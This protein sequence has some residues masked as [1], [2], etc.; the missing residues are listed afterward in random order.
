MASA[1]DLSPHQPPSAGCA[2]SPPTT[3]AGSALLLPHTENTSPLARC[4]ETWH[5]RLCDVH[6]CFCE[7]P[8]HC[9]GL[10][11]LRQLLATRQWCAAPGE[12]P[13]LQ[14]LE[15][16]LLIHDIFWGVSILPPGV[17]PSDI[18]P[19]EVPNYPST[20]LVAAAITAKLADELAAG[21]IRP[22]VERPSHL[23]AIY[24]K[25]EPGSVRVIS[26]FS[27]PEGR[28]LNDYTDNM[29][30][31]M[32]SHED[33]FAL[34]R[35]GAHMAKLDIRKA[36]RAIGVRPEQWH[37]LAFAWQD[38]TTGVTTY[39]I[40]TRLPFGHAK[41][42][43]AFCRIAA[44]VRAMM[45]A[46]GYQATINYVDDFFVVEGTA[47]ECELASQALSRLLPSLG[48][49]ENLP[50][51]CPPATQQI[52]LGLLYNTAALGP[53]PMTITV[54][55]DKLRRAERIA[56]SLATQSSVS[57][58]T[59]QSAIGFFN[60]ISYAIWAARA[61]SR[62]LIAAVTAAQAAGQHSIA[63]TKSLQLDLL[64]WRRFARTFNGTAVILH[65][66]CLYPGFFS[67]DASD[68]GFGGFL[69]GLSFSIP[70]DLAAVPTAV[71]SLPLAVRRTAGKL[72]PRPNTPQ[73]ADVAYRELFAMVW[74]FWLWGQAHLANRNATVAVT[75]HTDNNVI[76]AEINGFGSRN[77]FRMALLRALFSHAAAHNIR[78][79]ATRISSEANILA[80]AASRLDTVT[81]RRA[82][83]EWRSATAQTHPVWP[84]AAVAASHARTFRNP[85]LFTHRAALL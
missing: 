80:D 30:F 74:A 51:R 23:T 69:S 55:E 64:W 39:Y 56:A 24:G 84:G 11:P 27:A 38:P 72:W 81:F 66:P 15:A 42:P 68:L 34:L 16:E 36:Y 7:R 82:E 61:F 77:V 83:S 9:A 13:C 73:W 2:A 29:H 8:Q 6:S 57:V 18:P 59:L 20:P 43:E 4:I 53:H 67:T 22:V 49:E 26:D 70:W 58:S 44:A 48:F 62:R 14:A 3:A 1:T 50:K 35:P 52:F 76:L 46:Q 32:L 21:R 17:R 47:E 79:S 63:M 28:A 78:P 5:A 37:L 25:E 41:A 85:G 31:T 45:A 75:V 65:E 19:F 60:H 10:R 54:P 71:A 33:A 40:D 12:A